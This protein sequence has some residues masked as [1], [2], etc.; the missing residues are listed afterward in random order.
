[1]KPFKISDLEKLIGAALGEVAEG[2]RVRNT[3]G[4]N[5]APFPIDFA[6]ATMSVVI[7]P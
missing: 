1:M 3:I 6:T 5:S 4:L 7:V 2:K